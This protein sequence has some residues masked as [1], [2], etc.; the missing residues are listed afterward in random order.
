MNAANGVGAAPIEGP[1]WARRATLAIAIGVELALVLACAAPAA[2]P[3]ETA[4][5]LVETAPAGGASGSAANAD[6]DPSAALPNISP[7]ADTSLALAV[8]RAAGV[9]EID[10]VWSARDYERCLAVFADLLRSGRSDLPRRGSQ[11]SGALFARLVAVENF[12][13]ADEA[14]LP[15]RARRLQ[16]YLEAYPGLLQVYSP[17]SDGI[18]FS[19]EQTELIAS[20]LELLKSALDSTRALAVESRAAENRAAEN[21]AA[22]NRAAGDAAPADVYVRQQQMALG[23]VRGASAM[24]AEPERYAPPL[25]EYL[26]AA[27]V[28]SSPALEQHLEPNAA[29]EVRELVASAAPEG[30]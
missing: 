29:K 27:L 26:K 6:A 13:S 17:A 28:R 14:A 15:E 19:V 11:R 9:P 2:V 1:R 12:R 10:H 23:V 18:D 20:L 5:E 30:R 25:R 24:L 8:Y 7:D 4:P 21:R 3:I 22:E 16:G